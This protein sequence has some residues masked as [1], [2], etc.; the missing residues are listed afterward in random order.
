MNIKVKRTIAPV[1]GILVMVLVACGQSVPDATPTAAPIIQETSTAVP[2]NPSPIPPPVKLA[3]PTQTSIDLG[4][5]AKSGD[6]EKAPEL[7]GLGSWINST[8]F[9]L[10]EKQ[11]EGQVV[12]I[13]F[14]TY[15]CVNCIRTFPFLR[16]WQEKY[17]DRGLVI[18]GVHTPEFEFEKIRENVIDAT[19]E[20][21]IKWAVAQ[22]NDFGTWRAFNNRF[23]PAKYLIDTSGNIRYTHFGEGAY[24][25][26][27][28]WIRAML[29]EAGHD[30]S[31]IEAGTDPGP[32]IDTGATS[33]APGFGTTRELYAG[34]E[35]NFGALLS[36]NQPPYVLHEEYCQSQP[37]QNRQACHLK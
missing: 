23:W 2:N 31:D 34:Y 6:E 37:A 14:W 19:E 7:T 16:E 35:R 1:I 21:G 26:T 13:D 8:P 18:L 32:S 12:L 15:T 36:R 4:E 3:E 22:D 11:A 27:E 9:T 29:E 33:A 25:E 30:V 24:D 20:F 28:G 10:E 17:A 5:F